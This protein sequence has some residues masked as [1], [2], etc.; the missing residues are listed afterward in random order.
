MASV[1]AQK[2]AEYDC[3]ASGSPGQLEVGKMERSGKIFWPLFVAFIGAVLVGFFLVGPLVKNTMIAPEGNHAGA[4]MSK[5]ETLR[6]M[7]S[8]PFASGTQTRS[9]AIM[10]AE[11]MQT[12]RAILQSAAS[13]ALGMPLAASADGANS[14]TTKDRARGIYGSRIFALQGKSA[15][16]I[17]AEENAFKLF[18]S[19]AYREP[20][21]REAKEQKKKLT[22]L[23]KKILKAA[24]SGGDAQADLKQ[25]IAE[26]KITDQASLK[27]TIFNPK[28][29]R[30]PGA[31]PTEAIMA[32]MG[33]EGY[34][35]YQPLKGDTPG[36]KAAR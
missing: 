9:S 30:N 25:F 34:S 11:P 35:L 21:A 31:P 33:S 32:Q 17:V 28:Q 29:R 19:G 18:L 22:A 20:L 10:S 8:N 5:F 15:S 26:A 4:T 23:S 27:D 14:K 6:P 24:A 36:F 2:N 12:R 3:E 7:R 1:S 16:D 13:V